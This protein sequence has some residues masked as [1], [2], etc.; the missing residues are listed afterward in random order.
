[1][2]YRTINRLIQRGADVIYDPIESVH[3]S[4]HACQEEMRLM[5]NLVQPE[6]MLPVHG[7]LRHLQ[8]HAKLAVEAGLDPDKVFVVEN[9]TSVEI[10]QDGVQLGERYPGGYVYVDGSGVG[11]VGP[12]VIRDR[13]ILARD[14]FVIVSVNVDHQTGKL[15]DEPEIISRGFI[16]LRE[17]GDLIDQIKE[18][19]ENVLRSNRGS[20]NGNRQ[21][22]LEENIS[23]LLFHETKRRPMVFS[24]IN[25]V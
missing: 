20:K 13:E 21:D 5:I 9:G 11:D 22:I 8:L 17:A 1:M 3:V 7:E 15:I 18:N 6:H 16:Y 10:N 24:I 14:G 25:E 4:G 19:A 23:R 2:V 12:A